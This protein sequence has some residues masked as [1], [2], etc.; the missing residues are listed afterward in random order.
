MTKKIVKKNSNSSEDY[1]S[2]LT[3]DPLFDLLREFYKSQYGLD[4]EEWKSI[5]DN[6]R[7]LQLD[8]KRKKINAERRYRW[9]I[10]RNKL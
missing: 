3:G 10:K 9:K 6:D 4:S 8:K 7:R 2:Y 5:V 1:A